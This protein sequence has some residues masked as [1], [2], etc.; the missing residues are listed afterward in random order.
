L[1]DAP[2]LFDRGR[3]PNELRSNS[4]FSLSQSSGACAPALQSWRPGVRRLRTLTP[5]Q[6][7]GHGFAND[8]R[9]TL[10]RGRGLLLK[11]GVLNRVAEDLNPGAVDWS[12]HIL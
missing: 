11:R 5:I 1:G 6:S 8:R 10:L 7:V 2:S 4:S 12:V 3:F 9:G